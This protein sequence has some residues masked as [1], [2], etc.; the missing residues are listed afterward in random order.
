MCACNVCV[1]E[2]V[3][4]VSLSYIEKRQ[5]SILT[6]IHLTLFVWDRAASPA[7]FLHDQDE[8]DVS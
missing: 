8:G 7:A 1:R 2:C 6:C 3:C 5:I 4:V